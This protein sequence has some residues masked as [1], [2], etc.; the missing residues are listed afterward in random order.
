MYGENGALM[1]SELAALL[2]H[3]RIQQRLG[4]PIP[5]AGPLDQSLAAKEAVGLQIRQ[6]RHTILAWCAQAVL[7][8][9]PLVFSASLPAPA[10]PFRASTDAGTAVGELARALHHAHDQSSAGPASIQLLGTPSDTPLV[11]HWRHAARAAALAEHDTNGS[12][13]I[14]LTAAQ[15]QA[16]VGDVAA[17]TQ[18]LLVLDRRYARTPGWEKLAHPGRLGWAALASALDTGLGQPDYS[19]D[20]AGWR[21]RTKILRGPARPGILGVLQAQHNLLVRLKSFPDAMNLR[22]IVDSQRQMSSQLAPF[23]GRIDPRVA[24]RWTARATTYALIQQ[25]LRN[26]GGRLGTGGSAVAEAA[27]A[28]ARLGALPADTIVEPRVLA[29]FQ[30]L[31]DGLDHRIADI[32]EDGIDHGAFVDR[33]KLPQLGASTKRLIHPPEEKFVP[34]SRTSDLEVVRTLRER[35]RP[36]PV[37]TTSSSPGGSRADLHTAIL[38]RPTKQAVSPDLRGL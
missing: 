6:Y 25:Q 1:R 34:V 14:R 10:N 2:R 4:E 32:V 28:T 37:A 35:L 16:L 20:Q 19:I 31:F 29:G 5:N 18:A 9:K 33:I 23:A 21:P 11:E 30:T 15:A 36:P 17:V 13:G 7:A 3:H 22:L 24:E 8:S 12:T 26:I 38:H 27:N